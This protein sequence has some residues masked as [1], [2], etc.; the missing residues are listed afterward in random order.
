MFYKYKVGWYNSYD[1]KD[2][3]SEGMVYADNFGS[4]AD[5]V[6]NAYGKDNVFDI[7]LKEPVIEGEDDYCLSKEDIDNIFKED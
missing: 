1:N 2:E 3:Y 6:T 4:A 7:Y 5:R